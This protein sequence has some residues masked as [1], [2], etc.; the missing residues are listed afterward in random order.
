M[1]LSFLQMYPER[2]GFNNKEAYL[3]KKNVEV[4]LAKI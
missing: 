2:K 1:F 4:E 3:E